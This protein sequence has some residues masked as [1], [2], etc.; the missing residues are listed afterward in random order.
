MRGSAIVL[1]EL[2][3]REIVQCRKHCRTCTISRSSSSTSSTAWP[4]RYASAATV[5][6]QILFCTTCNILM[7]LRE[8][9]VRFPRRCC[10]VVV[11]LLT[12]LSPLFWFV[13]FSLPSSQ[14]PAPARL[15][16]TGKMVYYARCQY[17]GT[18][19]WWAMSYHGSRWYPRSNQ[20]GL[21]N[22]VGVFWDVLF[23]QKSSDIEMLCWF[24]VNVGFLKIQKQH[25]NYCQVRSEKKQ[26]LCHEL[27]LFLSMSTEEDMFVVLVY[28]CRICNLR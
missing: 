27:F 3:D 12:S 20:S 17:H 28:M 5:A 26:R 10:P 2:E 8:N 15:R 25:Q 24:Y 18:L 11:V 23:F 4:S 19:V 14:E 22:V 13:C 21:C 9:V 6:E 1:A 16:N 7:K